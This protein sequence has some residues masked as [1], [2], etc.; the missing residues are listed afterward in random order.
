MSERLSHDVINVRSYQDFVASTRHDGSD[1]DWKLR[2]ADYL[3]GEMIEA[4]TQHGGADAI[5]LFMPDRLMLDYDP[6]NTSP[7]IRYAIA[8][9]LGDSLWFTVDILNRIQ[10]NISNACHEAFQSFNIDVDTPIHTFADIQ[11][12]V[13]SNAD[14]IRYINK[15]G[16]IMGYDDVAST[17]DYFVTSIEQNPLLHITRSNRRLA[18]SL[19]DGKRDQ[20]PYASGAD[21]ESLSDISTA[22][23]QHLLSLAWLAHNR[24]GVT[25]NGIAAFNHAKLVHRRSYGKD[26]DIH[27]NVSYTNL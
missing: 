7:E 6:S 8:D 22:A 26:K 3:N 11:E 5:A 1:E 9:E 16:L 23:G 17:P 18:R 27:F 13:V 21:F 10:S 20:A 25:F 4:L 14:A 15:A 12:S 24:L 2:S 19:E